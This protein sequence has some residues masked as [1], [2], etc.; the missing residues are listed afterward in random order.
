MIASMRSTANLWWAL[1]HQLQ[2]GLDGGML[3]TRQPSDPDLLGSWKISHAHWTSCVWSFHQQGQRG[4]QWHDQEASAKATLDFFA[5]RPI[6]THPDPLQRGQPR[7]VGQELG[8]KTQVP[9]AHPK[10]N[11]SRLPP[12]GL[13]RWSWLGMAF[14]QWWMAHPWHAQLFGFHAEQVWTFLCSDQWLRLWAPQQ[15]GQLPQETLEGGTVE[16]DFGGR[17]SA[18][19]PWRS[20]PWWMS[21]WK[22]CSGFWILSQEHVR[23]HLPAGDVFDSADIARC[24]SQDL[25][26][27]WWWHHGWAREAFTRPATSDRGRNQRS[28]QGAS[29]TSSPNRPSFQSSLVICAEAQRSTPWSD[30]D[31]PQAS[32]PWMSRVATCGI[33]PFR[34]S[35]AIWNLVGDAGH[36]QCRIS[37]RWS[38]SSLHHHGGWGLTPGLS[39][40]PLPAPQGPEPQ[41]HWHW[42]CDGHPR[43]MDST[44]W[45]TCSHTSWPWRCIQI[46]WA[47]GMGT[48]TWHWSSSVC[49]RSPSSDQLGRTHDPDHQADGQ[50]A[51]SIWTTRPLG[52]D[53]VSLPSPQWVWACER[54]QSFSMGLWTATFTDWPFPWQSL[55]WSLLDFLSGFRHSD[56][57]Q[58]EA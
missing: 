26:S 16:S 15:Q 31:G 33:K 24:L 41:L 57:R 29:Q 9:K 56:G 14:K 17:P 45:R 8:Q 21:G 44:L 27:V 5:V 38:S 48:R 53:R 34:S 1:Q 3:P 10:W 58:L 20:S 11:S 32:V 55:W 35:T 4:A 22:R 12:I 28:I 13:G 25:P 18:S 42:S 37:N 50:A 7:E 39:P 46:E 19:L 30:P 43:F 54:L 23:A 51:S 36:R 52:S 47:D 6:L 2:P 40:F 49:R